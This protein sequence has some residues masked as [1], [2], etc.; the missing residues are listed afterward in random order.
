MCAVECAT[1][2]KSRQWKERKVVWQLPTRAGHFTS[3][4]NLQAMLHSP[5]ACRHI[6]CATDDGWLEHGESYSV[7]LVAPLGRS[8]TWTCED[9][10]G[11][12]IIIVAGSLCNGVSDLIV[13]Q[14]VMIVR[15]WQ[16]VE[17]NAPWHGI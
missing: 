15:T 9:F 1:S 11:G 17:L 7:Y 10:V 4:Q 13:L 3:D 5:Q 14:W 12:P 6:W 2:K 16:T 8:L